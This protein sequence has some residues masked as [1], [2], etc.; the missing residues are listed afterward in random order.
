MGKRGSKSNKRSGASARFS[1]STKKRRDADPGFGGEDDLDDQIDTFHKERDIIP[2]DINSGDISDD[3]DAE[4][5]VFDFEDDDSNDSDDS[6]NKDNDNGDDETVDRLPR[7]AAKMARQEKY[8]KQQMGGIDNDIHD[9][10]GESEEEKKMV[11]GKHK[12]MYFN[13][14]NGDNELTSSDDEDLCAEENEALKMQ[15]EKAKSFTLADYGFDEDEI[16]KDRKESTSK[17]E[18]KAIEESFTDGIHKRNMCEEVINVKKD[19]NAL[20]KEDQMNVVYSSA[21][22]LVGLLSELKETI[23]QFE[24]VD[25][26]LSKIKEKEHVREGAV[27]YIELKRMLLLIY[28][29]AIAFYL[30]LKSEGHSIRD[31]PVIARLVEIKNLIEKVKNIDGRIPFDIEEILNNDHANRGYKKSVTSESQ[32]GAIGIST[33]S[34]EVP[35][36][37]AQEVLEN[38]T[39]KDKVFQ[40]G[41]QSKEMLKARTKLEE[42]LKKNGIYNKLK[43]DPDRQQTTFSQPPTKRVKIFED[44]DDEVAECRSNLLKSSKLS[45]LVA[46]KMNKP[47]KLVSGEDDLPI[48]DDI[49]ERRR[50]HEIRVLSRAGSGL[51]DADMTIEHEGQEKKDL[52][53]DQNGSDDDEDDD[54]DDIGRSEDSED[55]FYKQV[56]GD[57]ISKRSAK[58]ET[59]KSTPVV[60]SLPETEADG[61]R[62]ISYQMEK[63]KGLTRSRK[64]DTKTPRKKYKIKH[65]KAVVRRRGQVRDIR[66]PSGPYGG[67]GSGI[68]TNISRSVRLNQ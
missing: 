66:K 5:P 2:L 55:D 3:D 34:Y 68:N 17:S 35:K 46:T 32:Y 53:M 13:A 9:M 6:N 29:Q 28:C 40:L 59:K 26:L 33:D 61:K 8:L 51:M 62:H 49:G 52:N 19:V 43:H 31:H 4:H 56:K 7:F 1:N 63:N 44:F 60:I 15:R 54:D 64:K 58:A 67:E 65:Q 45:Q 22:E 10:D 41:R 20:S 16:D 36:D 42:K 18:N 50:K 25:G 48:R 12:D 38:T 14:D 30:L 11:W 39:L 23:A 47:M 24:T 57:I 27:H 37:L 21:P